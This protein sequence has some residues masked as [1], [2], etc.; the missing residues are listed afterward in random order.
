MLLAMDF[1]FGGNQDFDSCGGKIKI[2]LVQESI[3]LDIKLT[4]SE[5]WSNNVGILFIKWNVV[6]YVR[7]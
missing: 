3:K 7:S 2:R 4:K 6:R 5:K 1:N